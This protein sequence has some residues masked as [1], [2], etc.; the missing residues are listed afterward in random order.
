MAKI[1]TIE[2][3]QQAVIALT[4]VVEHLGK[5]LEELKIM[6]AKHIE[7]HKSSWYWLIPTLL[8][9]IQIAI[10]SVVLSRGC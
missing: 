5:G 2:D 1:N 10:T 6:L 4:V 3:Y 7:G 8:L 9:L